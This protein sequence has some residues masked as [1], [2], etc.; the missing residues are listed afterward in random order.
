VPGAV[1]GGLGVAAVVAGLLLGQATLTVFGAV[2][3]VAG[4]LLA[5]MPRSPAGTG[6]M[7][8][9]IA[10]RRRAAEALLASAIGARDARL[11]E[12]AG[13]VS[14]H[15]L[16][17]GSEDPAAIAA[18]LSAARETRTIV[19]ERDALRV[20][21]E[22]TRAVVDAHVE[23]VRGLA[24]AAG[25]NAVSVTS[26]SA[27]GRLA[28][29]AAR[30][31]AERACDAERT[32]AIARLTDVEKAASTERAAA[33]SAR[34]AAFMRLQEAGVHE[35][36][37]DA[38]STAETEARLD[39]EDA[40]KAY[41]G[42]A[43]EVAGL[44]AR[45]DGAG[46]EDALARLHLQEATLDERIATSAREYVVLS[47]AARL[48]ATTQERYE[49]D[50]QP[51]VVQSAEAAFSRMTG[52]RYTRVTIPLGKESIE[53]FDT[54]S[55]SKLP[56]VLSRGT[57]EQLYLALRLG[58]IEQLGEVGAELPVIM[59]DILVNFSPDRLAPAAAAIA[60]LASSRQVVFFTCHPAMA[61]VLA[62]ASPGSVSLSIES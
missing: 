53:V 26:E 3:L 40:Q 41:D 11:A 37:L 60:D 54:S 46:R 47:L 61:R 2:L 35:N 23:R 52:G 29:V 59:D 31:A 20:S 56:S 19:D 24:V 55:A 4:A 8:A 5:L 18:R 45:I 28:R 16:G 32:S 9:D 36:D 34:S 10:A 39:A 6:A 17:D 12:W 21:I 33:D 14:G 50:R 51:A 25:E 44:H 13:W 57:A 22:Q 27:D 30:V 62:D 15:G 38:A 48:L 1:G 49:R 43:S 7:T 58:L 42:S